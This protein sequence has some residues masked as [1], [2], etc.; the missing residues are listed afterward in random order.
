MLDVHAPHASTH[1][2]TDFFIHIA[3]ICV[4]LLIAIGLEQTVEALH[5]RHQRHML[6]ENLREELRGDLPKDAEDFRRLAQMRAYIVQLKSA[7]ASRGSGE[8]TV[9]APSATDT[10]R[11]LVP[12]APTMAVWETAK[13]DA[14]LALLG[15]REID[16]YG[17]VVLQHT[18]LFVAI[19]DFQH[20]AFAL[21]SFEERFVDSEG[22]FEMGY[23]APPPDLDTLS[24][25]DRSTYEA[26]LATFIKAIDRTVVRVRFFDR[27]A[28][29]ILDGATTKAELMRR[30][31]PEAAGPPTAH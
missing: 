3:T 23:P 13:L 7:V 24:A 6:E 20:S 5:H 30:A 11:Q 16:L 25:A 21:E 9:A 2:W 15:P 10:R 12:S 14:S 29:A 8:R 28:R 18:L 26:L 4:G 27:A 31:F 17:A 19:D 1:T 22:A